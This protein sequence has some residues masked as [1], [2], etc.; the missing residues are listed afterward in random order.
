LEYP[1]LRLGREAYEAIHKAES[2]EAWQR[3]GAPP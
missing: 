1:V 2:F 3:I